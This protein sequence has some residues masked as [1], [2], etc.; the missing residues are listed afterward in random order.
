MVYAYDVNSH[1]QQYGLLE[2]LPLLSRV[3][4][5]PRDLYYNASAPAI[6]Q[7]TIRNISGTIEFDLEWPTPTNDFIVTEPLGMVASWS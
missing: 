5:V 3:D 4:A 2:I 1:V 6:A 7:H